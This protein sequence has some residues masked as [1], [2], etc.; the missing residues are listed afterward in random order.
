MTFS[1]LAT[2]GH[3]AIGMAVTS[4]SPAVAARCIHLRAGVGGAASQNVTDPRLGPAL[5][6]ALEAGLD[7]PGAM[8]Q[9]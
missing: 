4:S 9:V 7:A 6:D 5:L 8:A 2:D 3:G 1:L